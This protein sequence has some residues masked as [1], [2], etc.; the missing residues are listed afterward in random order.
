MEIN[1]NESKK[2]VEVWLTNAE[3]NDSAL[4]EN[5]PA[6]YR[7]Y[8]N[9]GYLV[10]VFESGSANLFD[11]TLSLLLHNREVFAKK[12]IETEK[13]AASQEPA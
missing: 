2:L 11:N 4:R 6:M 13:L 5:L 8:K 3:K 12:D 7:E 10:V 9:K 1:V